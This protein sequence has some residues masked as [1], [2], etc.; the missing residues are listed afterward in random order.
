MTHGKSFWGR[1]L[2]YGLGRLIPDRIYISLDYRRIFKTWPD[3]RNPKTYSEKLQ[4]LKL[5]DR[6]P[7]YRIIADK[8]LVRNYV[9]EKIGDGY[10]FPLLGVYDRYED[11]DFESLPDKFVL[12]PNHSSGDIFFCEDK[13]NINHRELKKTIRQWMR[14]DYYFE[15]REWQYK[16]IKRKLLCEKYMEDKDY[17]LPLN[18]KFMCFEG[19]PFIF[20]VSFATEG[21]K[22]YSFFD[23]ELNPVR[24]HEKYRLIE[25]LDKPEGF[26]ELVR[27]VSELSKPFN[28]IRMDMYLIEGKTFV[29]EF[30]QHGASGLINWEPPDYNYILGGMLKLPATIESADII[31]PKTHN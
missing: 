16:G 3:L 13:N 26:D 15:H 22:N 1:F 31:K 19:K 9:A 6:N 12:K 20:F 17:G 30:T 5:H 29:G 21:R 4:W 18:Y 8:L 14:Y 24:A 2:R 27:I 11:I 25:K 7:I 23:M 28:F 10:M